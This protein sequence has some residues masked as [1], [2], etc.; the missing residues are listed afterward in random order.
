MK[1]YQVYLIS[2]LLLMGQNFA[3]Y[4]EFIYESPIQK[5]LQQLQAEQKYG[6]LKSNSDSSS[7]KYITYEYKKKKM[8][9]API[10]RNITLL[11]K[12]VLSKGSNRGAI[13]ESG[14]IAE[15]LTE[16]FLIGTSLLN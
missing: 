12:Q 5:R 6:K 10:D 8:D 3:V 2:G 16:N 4:Q 11:R 14:K 1:K 15:V 9:F 13:S 7:I